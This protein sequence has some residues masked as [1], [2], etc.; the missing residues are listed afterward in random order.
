M[1]ADQTA[2][3]KQRHTAHR[4]W[5]RLR[6]DCGTNVAES[7]VRAYVAQV[8]FE[9]DNHLWA[10]TVPQAH[11]PGE[12]AE[13]DFGVLSAWIEGRSWSCGCSACG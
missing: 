13:V 5:A 3:R 9:L 2:P 11:R 7:T 8:R 4:V 10:V 1:T 6:D 12:E